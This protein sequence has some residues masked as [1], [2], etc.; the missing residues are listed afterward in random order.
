MVRAG[1]IGHTGL[2]GQNIIGSGLWFGEN[3]NSS[4]IDDIRGQEFDLLV[5]AGARGNRRLGDQNPEED[6]KNIENLTDRLLTV[7]VKQMILISTTEVY[8]YVNGINEDFAVVKDGLPPYALHRVMLEEFCR[9]HFKT[10]IV[11]LPI[12]Y[13]KG[14]KKNIIFDLFHGHYDFTNKD[15]LFQFYDLKNLLKDMNQALRVKAD[16]VNFVSQPIAVSDLA[17]DVFKAE[18]SNTTEPLRRFDIASKYW[19]EWGETENYL[20]SKEDIYNSLRDYIANNP[21]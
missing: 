18:L 21:L 11:R 5:C 4:N 6:L 3:F 17:R 2:V 7:K 20:Y 15:N 19:K 1:L 10:L 13:G 14:L 12:I 9:E 16:V 8:N